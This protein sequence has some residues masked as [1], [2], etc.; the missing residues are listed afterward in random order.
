V[1][2]GTFVARHAVR[3]PDRV[4]LVD[5][6]RSVTYGELDERTNRFAHALRGLGLAAG[7]RVAL[8]TGNRWEC[9]E[10]MVAAA[11][12]G[13]VFVPCDFRLDDDAATQL[14]RHSGARAAVTGGSHR[15]QAARL[16]A[17]DTPVRWWIDLDTDPGDTAAASYRAL[18]AGADAGPVMPSVGDGA[19]FCILYTSGTTGTPKGV[20]FTHQQTMDNAMAV[21]NE[22]E[23]D[24]QTRYL[25]SYPHSSA[26]SVNHVFGPV[27]MAGGRLVLCDV[28]NFEAGRYFTVV[29]RE[30][31][32]HSQLVPTMLF[33]L[34]ASDSDRK[35]DLSSLTTVGYASA[36]IPAP[37]VKQMLGR[38]GP[39]FVQ[40]YGMTE[41][42]SFATVLSKADHEAV[43][44]PRESILASC[45]R[46]TYGVEVQIV[47]E[48]DRPVPPRTLGEVVMRGRWLSRCYWRD[49]EL[50]AATNR[51]GWLHSGDVGYLD[52][53]D[54]LYLVD[55]KKDLLIIG[56]ANIASKEIEDVLY[57]VP[58]VLEAVVIG[59]P[60]EEWGER[61]HAVLAP[62]PGRSIDVTSALEH[63]RS[64]LPTIKQPVAVTVRDTMPKTST[65]K[66]SK[67]ELRRQLGAQAPPGSAAAGEQQ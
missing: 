6:G 60:D 4:A 28:R 17:A 43:G 64:R 62:A 18:I 31:V 61:P 7:D 27:L 13:L 19:G 37:R 65:G 36:P 52:E 47:D 34:L 11:K 45:G 23:I 32:T 53:Q 21:L 50:T 66:I 57:E 56:G 5:G 59:V 15:D 41:T 2:Y 1:H 24:A 26:G 14:L 46:A 30:R 63:C 39:V 20:F 33:R 55:R 40:A 16:A 54:Y 38:F 12:C 25:V 22:Y 29:E 67:P 10:V 35:R 42:C 9:V 3:A 44:G 8:I 49:P 51:G 58:G 48:Q